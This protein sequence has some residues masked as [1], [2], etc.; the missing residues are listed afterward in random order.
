MHIRN[1]L[2]NVASN[3]V[4]H[5]G[6]FCKFTLLIDHVIWDYG[7][8]ISDKRVIIGRCLTS[9]KILESSSELSYELK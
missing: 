4:I 7:Y 6:C 1:I 5:L 2:N 3:L 8:G 9:G